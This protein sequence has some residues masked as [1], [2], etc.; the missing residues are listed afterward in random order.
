M[1]H[2]P[3]YWTDELAGLL[4]PETPL[5][6]LLDA[7]KSCKKAFASDIANALVHLLEHKDNQVLFHTIEALAAI[8]K[9]EDLP[10]LLQSFS[11]HDDPEVAEA[12]RDAID[13][14]S[15]KNFEQF[16]RDNLGMELD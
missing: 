14:V 12:A 3:Q 2:F 15:R 7:V 1:G 4:K 9:T 5:P 13:M 6:L 16:M 11:L 8:N 10:E